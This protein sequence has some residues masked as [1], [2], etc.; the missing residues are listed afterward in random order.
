MHCTHNCTRIRANILENN[1]KMSTDHSEPT[2]P[3]NYD[4]DV[5]DFHI[6]HPA[7]IKLH[8]A[9]G[10]TRPLGPIRMKAALGVFDWTDP[11]SFW[12]PQP[13]LLVRYLL[14]VVVIVTGDCKNIIHS[15]NHNHYAG[16][17]HRNVKKFVIRGR[18]P[19]IP[20]ESRRSNKY[21]K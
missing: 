18:I 9:H 19:N 5:H 8:T 16:K 4:A 1:I 7:V 3:Q 14:I 12:L 6:N 15:V 17:M 21:P 13:P 10:H 2:H 20:H 11:L